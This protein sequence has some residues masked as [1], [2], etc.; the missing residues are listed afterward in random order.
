MLTEQDAEWIKANRADLTANRTSE[1]KVIYK[2]VTKRDPFTNEPIEENEVPRAVQSVVT[3]IS[4]ATSAGTDRKLIDGVAVEQGDLWVSVDIDL[5]T[6]IL[7][8]IEKIEYDG[9][10]YKI[11]ALDKKGVGIINRVE[12]L[13]KEVS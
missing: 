1:I 7:D 6:D 9:K 5:V 11:L 10:Q 2:D 8:K 3:E 12:I 4:S 13:A